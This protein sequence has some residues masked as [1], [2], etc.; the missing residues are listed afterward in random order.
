VAMSDPTGLLASPVTTIIR[1]N[2][3]KDLDK[4]VEMVTDNEVEAIVVG[5]P[6]SL[7]GTI[8]PQGQKTLDFCDL[9]REI[10]P[11]PIHM[12][13][14]QYTS[15]EAERR[16]R[17][18]GGEPSKDKARVDAVAAAIILQ[19]WLDEARP[20]VPYDETPFA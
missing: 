5:L 1:G 17:E 13:N 15:A 20:P 16:I 12:C 3:R 7:N 11:V 2:L 4:I 8:G 6:V 10:S 14:E 9:L 18:A 19:E